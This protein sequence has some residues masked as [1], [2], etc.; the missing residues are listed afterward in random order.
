MSMENTYEKHRKG[1]HHRQVINVPKIQVWNKNDGKH[2]GSMI[3]VWTKLFALRK[4]GKVE[5]T[6]N[7][8]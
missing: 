2:T 8:V 3:A 1:V 5:Y 4:T 6:L 7:C